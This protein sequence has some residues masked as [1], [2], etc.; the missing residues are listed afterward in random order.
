MPP[1]CSGALP[2]GK[3]CRNFHSDGIQPCAAANLNH[4]TPTPSSHHKGSGSHRPLGLSRSWLFL[5][6]HPR[7][8]LCCCVTYGTIFKVL[9]TFLRRCLLSVPG[10]KENTPGTWAHQRPK[11]TE[12]EA[13]SQDGGDR[14]IRARPWDE[15]VGARVWLGR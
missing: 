15:D 8:A 4:P 3:E 1:L 11:E 9:C 7:H 2:P 12:G 10:A 13:A 6:L 5:L 14:S